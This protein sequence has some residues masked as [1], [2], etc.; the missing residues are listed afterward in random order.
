M[1]EAIDKWGRE[2]V[3]GDVV[4]SQGRLAM[5]S[6]CTEKRI[7]VRIPSAWGPYDGYQL[8]QRHRNDVQKF[9]PELA[10]DFLAKMAEAKFL[11]KKY[12]KERAEEKRQW[13]LEMQQENENE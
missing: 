13:L 4:I 7:M 3:E 1:M 8:I 10:D 5:F 2:L 11:K 6:H 9:V 12:D